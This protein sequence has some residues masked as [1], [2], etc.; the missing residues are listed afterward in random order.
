MYVVQFTC[1]EAQARYEHELG[2]EQSRQQTGKI[3]EPLLSSYLHRLVEFIVS[4]VLYDEGLFDTSNQST[5]VS[6]QKWKATKGKC[7][8]ILP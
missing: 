1:V 4:A 7:I 5:I 8:E 6:I 2:N 3:G